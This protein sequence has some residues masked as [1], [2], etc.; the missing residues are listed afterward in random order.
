VH[1]Y[2]LDKDGLVGQTRDG[3]LRSIFDDLDVGIVVHDPETAEILDVNQRLEQLY[4]YTAAELRSMS[5][6]DYTAPSTKYTQAKAVR[7][8]RATADGESQQ[9]KWQIERANGEVRWVEVNLNAAT[10]RGED[11]VIAEVHDITEE[12]AREQRLRLLSRILRHNLRNKMNVVI[13][14]AEMVHATAEDG[15]GRNRVEKIL[16]TAQEVGAMT[17]SV[18]QI[19]EIAGPDATER[20]SRDASRLVRSVVDSIESQHPEAN[21]TVDAQREATVVVDTGVRYAV[22][23]AIENAIVHNDNE[24]PTV[25]ISISGGSENDRAV[26]RIADDGPSI[27]EV[28]TSVLNQ[29]VETSSTFHGSGVGL[30]VMQ[31]CVRSI[32]GR[33]SFEENTPRGNVVTI[34]L[35]TADPA[36]NEQGSHGRSASLD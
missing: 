19:E 5:V 25:D 27:P 28:E 4:G 22:E 21:V 32:G 11:C 23:H 3:K 13:S 1:I 36:T 30:W 14:Q 10:L 17:D 20:S 26:I 24:R 29:P 34:A 6:E 15:E 31:W 18:R 7:R 9:F 12:H 2:L 33:L 8:I 16:E 35:P